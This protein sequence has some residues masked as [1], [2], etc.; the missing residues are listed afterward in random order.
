MFNITVIDYKDQIRKSITFSSPILIQ[1]NK[2]LLKVLLSVEAFLLITKEPPEVFYKIGALKSFVK[3]PGKHL[4]WNLFS[5]KVAGLRQF[6]KKGVSGTGVF[7]G[8]L[9]NFQENIF[10]RTPPGVCFH[11]QFVINF[12]GFFCSRIF[13]F[14]EKGNTRC[15]QKN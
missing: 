4:C 14:L 9:L 5:T 11:T 10:Y 7:L 15:C 2:I 3:F 8:I 13:I 1:L 12:Y 6:I